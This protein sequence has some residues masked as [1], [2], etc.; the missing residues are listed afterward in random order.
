MRIVRKDH[1]S[2]YKTVA[3]HELRE[4]Q[5]G[6]RGTRDEVSDTIDDRLSRRQVFIGI[7]VYSS[8]GYQC[9]MFLFYSKYLD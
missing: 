4:H 1:I 6:G 5:G 9:S 3:R 2:V 7:I 8:V